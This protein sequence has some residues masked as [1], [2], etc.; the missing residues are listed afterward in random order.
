M[1]VFVYGTLKKGRGNN[2]RLAKATFIGEALVANYKLLNAGFP[3]AIPAKDAHTTGELWDIGNPETDNTARE[4][5]GGLDRLEGYYPGDLDNCMYHRREILT[6][7]GITAFMYVG[8]PRREYE[9]RLSEMP[10][11]EQGVYSWPD[12]NL[13]SWA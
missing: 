6:T 13:H 2:H 9:K 10:H 3:V 11:D 12:A 1:L 8:N 7:E 4:I 5:L